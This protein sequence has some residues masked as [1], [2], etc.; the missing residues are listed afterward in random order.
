MRGKARGIKLRAGYVR[1]A[2]GWSSGVAVEYV[3]RRLG[4]IDVHVEDEHHERAD[5]GW[6]VGRR[7]VPAPLTQEQEPARRGVGAG[8]V[9]AKSARW[10]P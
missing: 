5:Q 8:E 3:Q 10:L 4:Q 9:L 7:V 1:V 2:V 6:H